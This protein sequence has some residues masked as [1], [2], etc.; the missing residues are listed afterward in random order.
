MS[1]TRINIASVVDLTPKIRSAKI[2]IND[3]G[4]EISSIRYQ[5]NGKIRSRRNIDSRICSVINEIV[6]INVDVENIKNVVYNGA[7]DYELTERWLRQYAQT[8]GRSQSF[9]TYF[10]WRYNRLKAIRNKI[11]K[12]LKKVLKKIS[13]YHYEYKKKGKTKKY[14]KLCNYDESFKL[15]GTF[16]KFK[17]DAKTNRTHYMKYKGT[18]DLKTGDSTDPADV[19][20]KKATVG[21]FNAKFSASESLLK[22]G[23]SYKGKHGSARVDAVVGNAE[24]HG[25]VSGGFYVYGKDGK[26]K[27]APGVEAEFGTSITALSVT[28]EAKYGTKYNNINVAG[29]V[30]EGRAEAVVDSELTFLGKKGFQAHVGAKAEAIAAGAEA[31]GGITVLGTGIKATGGVNLGAGAH[32][33]AGIKDGKINLDMGL[34]VGV[35]LKGSVTIDMTGTVDAIVHEGKSVLKV[36]DKGIDFAKDSGKAVV[37]VA[38]KGAD[39]VGDGYHAAKKGFGKVTK[40]ASGFVKSLF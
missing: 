23:A 10:T 22:A 28:G 11:S 30:E 33:D 34:S 31:T 37:N 17:K 21:E 14:V 36:A 29:K 19:Y 9:V 3:A 13:K 2:H 6:Q 4:D 40:G 20:K 25:S 27:F 39:V 5:L 1:T 7:V 24:A 26:R 35:G 38:E 15:S 12:N 18:K 8:L 16:G 32:F